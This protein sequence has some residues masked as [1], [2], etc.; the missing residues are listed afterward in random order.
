MK[1]DAFARSRPCAWFA[2]EYGL[3][4]EQTVA[5]VQLTLHIRCAKARAHTDV[6]VVVPPVTHQGHGVDS[7]NFL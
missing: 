4:D 5:D 1:R 6:H 2:L 3:D 7:G